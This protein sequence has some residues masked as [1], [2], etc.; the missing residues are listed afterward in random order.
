MSI[1]II[2]F[3]GG[4]TPT[5]EAIDAEAALDALILSKMKGCYKNLL[6]RKNNFN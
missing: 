1:I 6:C 4:P 3:P 2:V 5:Q